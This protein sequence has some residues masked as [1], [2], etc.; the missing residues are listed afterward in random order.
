MSN[1]ASTVLAEQWLCEVCG[2]VLGSRQALRKHIKTQHLYPSKFSRKRVGI[3]IPK[4][5]SE[6]KLNIAPTP[7]TTIYQAPRTKN[8]SPR[9]VTPF[10]NSFDQILDCTVEVST[11]VND[12]SSRISLIDVSYITV[13]MARFYLHLLFEPTLLVL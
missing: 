3:I 7:S 11:T 9:T 12:K 1:Q 6:E 2:W 4:E 13:Y 8:V 10:S 5:K